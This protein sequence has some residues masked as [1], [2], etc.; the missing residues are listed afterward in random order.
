[1]FSWSQFVCYPSK[2]NASTDSFGENVHFDV[3]F[4]RTDFGLSRAEG[5]LKEKACCELYKGALT[6]K[7]ILLAFAR[8]MYLDAIRGKV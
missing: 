8:L 1:V 6:S 2:T 4:R 7:I 5:R 3:N